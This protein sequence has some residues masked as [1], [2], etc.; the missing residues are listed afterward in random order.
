M[1]T[2]EQIERL[3]QDVGFDQIIAERIATRLAARASHTYDAQAIAQI[4]QRVRGDVTDKVNPDLIATIMDG[5]VPQHVQRISRR[6]EDLRVDQEMK[7]AVDMVIRLLLSETGEAG[8]KRTRRL[9]RVA[10][11]VALAKK[12]SRIK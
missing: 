1:Y 4:A 9:L 8:E 5:Q 10:A 7:L 2:S 12:I 3:K 11:I 6:T